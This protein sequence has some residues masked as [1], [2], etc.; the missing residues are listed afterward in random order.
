MHSKTSTVAAAAVVGVVVAAEVVV[1]V[2]GHATDI[3]AGGDG[4]V[5]GSLIPLFAGGQ[6]R[7]RS[8]VCMSVCV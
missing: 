1:A 8:C 5:V 7:S 3:V 4:D 6:I 2:L